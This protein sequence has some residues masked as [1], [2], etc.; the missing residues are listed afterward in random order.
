MPT[1]TRDKD[2]VNPLLKETFIFRPLHPG[3]NLLRYAKGKW[4]PDNGKLDMAF[5]YRDVRGF[6]IAE[7]VKLPYYTNILWLWKEIIDGRLTWHY[8]T[9]DNDYWYNH[10]YGERDEHPNEIAG[11]S[12][13]HKCSDLYSCA[14]G[15]GIDIDEDNDYIRKEKL[16]IVSTSD[17][18][19]KPTNPICFLCLNNK[20]G[21]RLDAINLKKAELERDKRHYQDEIEE[22]MSTQQDSKEYL[23]V[24]DEHL[25][26]LDKSL[27]ELRKEIYARN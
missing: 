3:S 18:I 22:A 16:I 23:R 5:V 12:A 1:T 13:M 4:V 21:H 14:N 2:L 27:V 11:R 15:H 25:E 9:T 10:N 6:P 7:Y 26:A 17:S 19:V 20:Y 8:C 24:I